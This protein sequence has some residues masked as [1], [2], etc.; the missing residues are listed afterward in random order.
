MIWYSKPSAEYQTEFLLNKSPWMRSF[1]ERR[2]LGDM[3]LILKEKY[4][5]LLLISMVFCM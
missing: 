5:K 4:K 2:F 3:A 1:A